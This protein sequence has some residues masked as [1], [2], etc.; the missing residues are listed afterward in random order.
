MLFLLWPLLL[1]PQCPG[2]FS[3]SPFHS[4]RAESHPC[5]PRS[6]ELLAGCHWY[7]LNPLASTAAAVAAAAAAP[8]ATGLDV[9]ALGATATA[10][11][12]KTA[13]P[14]KCEV[15]AAPFQEFQQI[16]CSGLRILYRDCPE[17]TALDANHLPESPRRPRLRDYLASIFKS[18]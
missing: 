13:L 12:G 8:E 2:I 5:P 9:V 1:P 16:F 6:L 4:R 3:L 17:A 15:R 7:P 11:C 10:L 18:H 14:A